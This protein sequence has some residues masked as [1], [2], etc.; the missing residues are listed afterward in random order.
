[1][2]TYNTPMDGTRE[3][4]AHSIVFQARAGT[5]ELNCCSVN[6][7]RSLG[8]LSEWALMRTGDALAI[9]YYGPLE[10]RSRI[11]DQ[12][13]LRLVEETSYPRDG[14]VVI[15]LADIER[16]DGPAS[17]SL[18]L[19]IPGWSRSTSVTVNGQPWPGVRPG[20]YLDIE[21]VWQTG[22]KVE[23]D[24]DMRLRYE[25]GDLDTSGCVSLYR[26]PL[27]LAFDPQDNDFDSPAIGTIDV[28][29]LDRA[30]VSDPRAA[31]SGAASFPDKI[32][33]PW[34]L[35][36]LP[37]AGE[38]LLRL[39]DFASAGSA[40]TSYRTWLKAEHAAPPAPVAWLPADG[41]VVPAG[42]MLFTWRRSASSEKNAQTV[43][44]V[45]TTDA[46]FTKPLI[47][48]GNATSE[49]L[50]LPVD[51]A[52]KLAPG[53][54]YHWKVVASN[55]HGKTESVGPAKSFCVDPKLPPLDD[56]ALLTPH[57]ERADGIVVEA[58]LVGNP[59]PSYGKLAEARGWQ[60]FGTP[61]NP[62]AGAV[63]LDGKTGLLR[64]TLQRFPA[65]SYTLAVRCRFAES[66]FDS[67]RIE[68]CQQVASAWCRAQDDPLR[69]CLDHGK[70]FARIEA[71][72]SGFTTEG[73]PVEPARWYHL[74]VVKDG[75]RLRLFIDGQ[76]RAEALVPATLRTV[77]PDL[78]LG[79]NPHFSGDEYLEA[80]LA[81]F[82]LYARALTADEVRSLAE[83]APAAK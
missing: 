55:E 18:R 59:T 42:R 44:V 30:V 82:R 22:D 73:V 77:A 28:Q 23:L 14:H 56:A 64:Y 13:R 10:A 54:T 58:P 60:T 45:I 62:T 61:D 32:N 67:P 74:A 19:R 7:P 2:W 40:G 25:A 47:E 15:R 72:N 20:C 29:Q 43:R 5:P 34:V 4:S 49:F 35:V 8:M 9:N 63:E 66:G 50:I 69:L 12:L 76:M 3:A 39:R 70:L 38:R 79:G 1:W 51:E 36:D 11:N 27:L 78:A 75:P 46:A 16:K 80:R 17:F 81:D 6:G 37:L 57:G 48:Y 26:G 83:V 41:S 21:R 24:L 31:G 52:N 33:R 71:G 53:E 65:D 68:Q